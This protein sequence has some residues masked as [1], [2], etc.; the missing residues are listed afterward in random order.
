M[1]SCRPPIFQVGEEVYASHFITLHRLLG[2]EKWNRPLLLSPLKWCSCM[3]MTTCITCVLAF[4]E[5]T[6]W[7]TKIGEH[8]RGMLHEGP[9][10]LS[11]D[12]SHGKP[13]PARTM[14]QT[15]TGIR[16]Y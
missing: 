12:V 16:S 15:T 3:R 2:L 6:T 10:T 13:S 11:A 4:M 8:D 9:P 7:Q 14:E 1:K 5:T